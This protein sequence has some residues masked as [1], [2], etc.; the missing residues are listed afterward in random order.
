MFNTTSY[1]IL[2]I[3]Y[4]SQH[5][6][7]D[8]INGAIFVNALIGAGVTVGIDTVLTHSCVPDGW[9]VGQGCFVSG[10]RGALNRRTSGL[11]LCLWCFFLFFLSSSCHV[12]DPIIF[13]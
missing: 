2:L 6:L 5:F 7:G 3:F 12:I 1:L 10:I 8:R 13:F 4:I 11:S 9:S